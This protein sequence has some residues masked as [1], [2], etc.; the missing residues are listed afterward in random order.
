MLHDVVKPRGPYRL[1][2]MTFGRSYQTPLPGGKS[3]LA[4]QLAD[5]RVELRAPDE[6]ALATLRFCLAL[7]ADT[8]EFLRRFRKDPVI[9]PSI[10]NLYGLR[11]LRRPTVARAALHAICGQLVDVKTAFAIERRIMDAI[12]DHAP[13]REPI[14]RLSPAELRR[15]GL[16][17]QRASALVRICRTIDLEALR[18]RPIDAVEARLLRERGLGPWSLGVISL[19]GIGSYRHGLVGDLTLVK[20]CSAL[21]GRWVEIYETAELLAPYEEW[22]GL[23]GAYLMKGWQ[24]GLVPGATVDRARLV[25]SRAA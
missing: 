11:P 16:A 18:D 22:A 2:L 13:T 10:R 25:R 8:T 15:F 21:W 20:L 6:G 24:S 14:G 4:W 7:E 5:G 17:T 9:G 3:G 23:A 19:H 12:G 1:N